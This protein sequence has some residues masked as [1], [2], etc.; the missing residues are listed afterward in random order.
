MSKGI[1]SF[2]NL[3]TYGHL[4]NQL[5]QIASTIGIA[6]ENEMN[7]MFPTWKYDKFFKNPIPQMNIDELKAIKGEYIDRE[8]P[9]HYKPL[10]ILENEKNWD[11]GGY[12]Q[13][14]KY[15]DSNREAVLNYFEFKDEYIDYLRGKYGNLLNR[16]NVCSLHVRRGDYLNA[17]A[18]HP[19]CTMNYYNNAIS[20]FPEDTTFLVFT[21]DIPWCV[22]NFNRPNFIII[23]ECDKSNNGDVM[24]EFML[25]SLCKNNI[26]ANST[27]SLWASILNKNENKKVICPS[28][29]FGPAMPGVILSDMYPKNSIVL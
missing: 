5:Y 4:G 3:G 2:T 24:M 26:T 7:Y 19:T 29:W 9:H 25:M 12:L 8:G 20:H 22:A 28:V 13:T 16:E 21:N 11:I 14:E 15:F 27:F 23:D 1:L 10:L 18:Y 17:P 6:M